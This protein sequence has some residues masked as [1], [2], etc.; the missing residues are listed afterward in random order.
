MQRFLYSDI[1]ECASDALNNCHHNATC[2][3][4]DGSY[5]CTCKSGSTGDGIICRGNLS[6]KF[7]NGKP[8]YEKLRLKARL[9]NCIAKRNKI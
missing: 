2:T 4:T 8:L 3:D 9:V 1:D 7:P 6:I 5:T